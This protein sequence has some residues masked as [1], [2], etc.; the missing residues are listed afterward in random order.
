MTIDGDGQHDP[1]DA[2]R[3]LAAWRAH[4]ERVVIGARLHDRPSIPR[5]RYLGESLRLLLDLVGRGPP[6]RRLADRACASIPRAVMAI[7]LSERVPGDRFTFESE[8][9]IEA[10]APRPPDPRR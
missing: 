7:A 3:L 4:P 9:L 10:A 5:A 6:D 2:A 1:G 8:V